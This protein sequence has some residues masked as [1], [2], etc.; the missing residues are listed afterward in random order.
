VTPPLPT[1]RPLAERLAA[2]DG[3]AL[4]FVGIMLV[5]IFGATAFVV[6]Y[7]V[8][9]LG[10]REAQ[11]AAD[12]GALAGAVARAYDDD[13]MP[14]ASGGIA[15]TAARQAALGNQVWSEAPGVT[16]GWECPPGIV[17][18][19]GARC[20]Q[21]NV[22]RDGTNASEPLPSYFG[23]L[24]GRTTQRVRATATAQAVPANAS[25][26]LRPW[27]VPDLWIERRAPEPQF[28]RYFDS[29]PNRGQL[30]PG[31]VDEYVYPGYTNA[32]K[33]EQV[34]LKL[35]N[36]TGPTT[37]GW[38]LAVDIPRANDTS[39][40]GAARYR[41]NIASCNGIATRIGQYLNTES[42]GK[43]GPTI[44]GVNELIAQDPFAVWDDETDSVA[45]S[46]GAG[47]PCA[48]AIISPRIVVV[49][50]FDPDDFAQR[51][52]TNDRAPC[53]GGG[54]C[55]RVVNMFGFFVEEVTPGND[56]LGRLVA[57][58][59]EFVEGG[60]NVTGPGAFLWS[61]RMVR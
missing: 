29:G 4:V 36:E 59:G 10:R 5:V 11:N 21:V 15:D 14:P 50:L 58:R 25:D 56:V 18:P 37:S 35:G 23:V 54:Q 53:S 32:M 30:M 42:G 22:F 55:V 52:A 19:A 12:A 57:Q 41:E 33:G 51:S 8:M 24:L 43:T 28:N 45:N 39:V 2:E 49:A 34:T 1:R 20:A 3:V 46:C 31:L 16:V 17:A 9:W 38:F 48:G 47:S 26:C 40:N 7:G 44:Q 61:I 6:D 27:A 13:G 60:W